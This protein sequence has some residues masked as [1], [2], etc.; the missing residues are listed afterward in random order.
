[1]ICLLLFLFSDHSANAQDLEPRA[2]A[3]APVS[4]NFIGIGYGYSKGG[5]EV[6]P[7]VPLENADIQIHTL[8]FAYV[9]TLDLWGM[10]S[11][12]N[13]VLPYAC[14]SGSAE[15]DGQSRERD[16]CGMADPHFSL[17]VNFYGAPALSLKEFAVYKQ[18]LII[19][20]SLKVIPP[21]G[22]YDADKLL[23]IGT[24][25]WSFKPEIGLS[26]AIGPFKVEFASGI[27]V[28]TNNSNYLSGKTLEL[29]PIYSVQGHL[30]YNFNAGIWCAIDGTYYWGGRKTIDGVKGGT[31]QENSRLG[32]TLALPIDRYNSLKLYAGTGVY[33][34][35]GSNFNT[36]GIVWQY[37]W[38]GGL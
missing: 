7:A 14:A 30:I 28:Y 4:L 13:V 10:S 36:F 9:R 20:A 24:N 31:L 22:Q 37:R 15:V 5:V 16:V 18:D 33:T 23:N 12:F 25:R 11:K 8:L 2:Y 1:M 27:T 35:R 17:S 21:L 32:T 3:N 19:G 26:K 29:D 34:R 6:D 38:G